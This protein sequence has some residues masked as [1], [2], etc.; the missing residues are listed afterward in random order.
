MVQGVL[1]AVRA[2]DGKEILIFRD[3]TNVFFSAAVLC[4]VSPMKPRPLWLLLY[5]FQQRYSL[6]SPIETTGIQRTGVMVKVE[7]VGKAIE[8][9]CRLCSSPS[10]GREINTH[11]QRNH[12]CHAFCQFILGSFE[13]NYM[14]TATMI[15]LVIDLSPFPHTNVHQHISVPMCLSR[16]VLALLLSS[17]LVRARYS[18]HVSVSSAATPAASTITLTVTTSTATALLS[19]LTILT[20]EQDEALVLRSLHKLLVMLTFNLYGLIF[21]QQDGAT[22]KHLFAPV[23]DWDRPADLIKKAYR[24]YRPYVKKRK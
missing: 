14:S 17:F 2:V 7:P 21:M 15:L 8:R 1:A 12:F 11:K 10:S 9:F 6:K 16:E 19:S 4:G 22:I 24:R 18:N 23:M 5:L 20:G 3:K 13:Q